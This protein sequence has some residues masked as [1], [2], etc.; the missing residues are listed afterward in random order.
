VLDPDDNCPDVPNAGQTDEDDDG[1]GNACDNCPADDNLDQAN[2]DGDELG[3]ACDLRPALGG[4]VRE[5][6]AGFNAALILDNFGGDVSNFS[7]GGGSLT[8]GDT[9][10]SRAEI[11]SLDT[12]AQGN[13]VVRTR[14][15]ITTGTGGDNVALLIEATLDDVGNSNP[16]AWACFLRADSQGGSHFISAGSPTNSER[17]SIPGVSRGDFVDVSF[18]RFGDLLIC[19]INS[20]VNTRTETL[21]PG[22]RVGFRGSAEVDGDFEF[23]EVTRY[24]APP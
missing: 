14:M 5:L 22:S 12:F 19:T 11:E 8:V 1:V 16:N 21:H 20:T 2:G 15:R 13:L 6:F 24:A 9:P 4:D 23:L 3:D 17:T 18:A 10:E 7:T